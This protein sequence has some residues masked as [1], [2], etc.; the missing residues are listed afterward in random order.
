[1]GHQ[2]TWSTLVSKLTGER[3]EMKTATVAVIEFDIDHWSK[4]P[5]AHG[6][7]AAVFH[8]RD[9]TDPS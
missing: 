3:A 6:R 5:G 2:P 1:V 9:Y 8:P 7:L 4:L